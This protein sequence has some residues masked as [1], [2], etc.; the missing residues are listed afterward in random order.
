MSSIEEC[1]QACKVFNKLQEKNK[2]TKLPIKV[3]LSY[4]IFIKGSYSF[5]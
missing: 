5:K 3:I 4:F 1:E 2:T